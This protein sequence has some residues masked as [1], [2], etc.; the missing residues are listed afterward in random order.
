[1]KPVYILQHLHGD[2]PAYLQTWLEQQG[3]PY[4]VFN[5]QA[6]E[7]FPD[8][9]GNCSG[10]A[11]LG[12]EMSANDP[13]PSLRQAEHLFL[14]AVRDGVPTLGHCLGG[15]L[16]ARAL[17]ALV[18]AS[19]APE[20]GW[21]PL[22]VLGNDRARAWLAPNGTLAPLTVFHWHYEAFQLPAGAQLLATSAACPVQAFSVGPH[23]AMQWHVE[24]DAAKLD[25][26]SR[27]QSGQHEQACLE[28]PKTVHSGSEMRVAAPERLAQQQALARHIYG[29]WW[30]QVTVD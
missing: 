25:R 11:I 7:R 12:G 3:L 20:V 9:L 2:G 29:R 8:D 23:L 17:G 10:L 22:T 4:R 24:L 5:T 14:E 1:M 30:A 15:Q 26:W 19:P 16:M 6:G 13:L 18:S 21:Q 27:E 28:H